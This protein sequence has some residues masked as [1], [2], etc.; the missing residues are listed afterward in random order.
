[1]PR[2]NHI[3]SLRKCFLIRGR[4]KL[5]SSHE[6]LQTMK[7]YLFPLR[8]CILVRIGPSFI[9]IVFQ[10]AQAGFAKYNDDKIQLLLLLFI[11][12][13]PKYT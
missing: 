7:A 3:N 2:R 6:L 8:A 13:K 9:L 1:M 5:Q 11:P 4:A 12:S 10:T